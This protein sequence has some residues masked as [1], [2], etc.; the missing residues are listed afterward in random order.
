MELSRV[1]AVV[2]LALLCAGEAE[3]WK[4]KDLGPIHLLKYVYLAD[5]AYAERHGGTTYTGAPWTF[6]HFGPWQ[7]QVHDAIEPALGRIGATKKQFPS[8]FEKDWFRWNRSDE[9][10]LRSLELQLPVEVVSKVKK[11]VKTYGQDTA[12]LLHHVYLTEPMLHA[13][14]GELLDFATVILRVADSKSCHES[15]SRKQEKKRKEKM[16]A[17]RSRVQEKLREKRQATAVQDM[18]APRYDEV[19]E[20]R[21]LADA[22]ESSPPTEGSLE[23]TFDSSVFDSEARRDT[24]D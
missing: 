23:V 2:Q 9:A 4:E 5:L 16:D 19:F 12:S 15:P 8:S 22:L 6:H 14:P 18:R 1:E 3:D 10:K 7:A 13:A 17:L 20:R 11:S 21:M 24:R